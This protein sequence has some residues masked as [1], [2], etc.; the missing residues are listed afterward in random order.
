[1]SL[2][3]V[4]STSWT[5]TAFFD[6][7]DCSHFLESHM[8]LEWKI[9]L[10][11]PPFNFQFIARLSPLKSKCQLSAAACLGSTPLGVWLWVEGDLSALIKEQMSPPFYESAPS[12]ETYC[13]KGHQL[14]KTYTSTRAEPSSLQGE[15]SPGVKSTRH[16]QDIIDEA[17]EVCLRSLPFLI[18][19]V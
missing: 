18:D 14:R 19:S 4:K 17:D 6:K 5:R 9:W 13:K 2:Y 10:F 7:L 12:P 1:M 15:M 8:R 16:T 3:L 11:F